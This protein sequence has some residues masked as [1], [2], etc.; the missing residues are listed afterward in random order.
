MKSS[1]QEKKR[2]LMARSP[3]IM[4][5]ARSEPA[6]FEDLRCAV[7]PFGGWFLLSQ[8]RTSI[9]CLWLLE[10]VTED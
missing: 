8:N 7:M 3:G 5:A 4:M 6:W 10:A 9:G 2:G 1:C